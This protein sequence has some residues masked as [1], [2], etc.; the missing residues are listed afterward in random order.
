MLMFLVRTWHYFEKMR[1]NVITIL[2]SILAYFNCQFDVSWS[3]LG[4]RELGWE[5]TSIRLACSHTCEG[6]ALIE[7]CCRVGQP[8]VIGIIPKQEGLGCIK[9]SSWENQR[10][11]ATKQHPFSFCLWTL[12]F[13]LDFPQ[14]WTVT[15]K[16]KLEPTHTSSKL[17]LVT[18][19]FQQQKA[20]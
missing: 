16:C 1:R 3:R 4:R 20:D 9:K 2:T 7:D 6:N 13:L 8:T 17:T 19:L 18:C 10:E 14:G 5:I 12:E 15:W 11:Q